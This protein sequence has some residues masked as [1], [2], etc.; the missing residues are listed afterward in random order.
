[1][2][3]MRKY[4][5]RPVLAGAA[6]V[7][8]GLLTGSLTA[9]AA[10]ARSLGLDAGFPTP[11]PID[12]ITAG[13]TGT[14]LTVSRGV[15]PEAFTVTILGVLPDGIGPGVDMIVF[16]GASPAL[17]LAGGIWAGM[18]GSPVYAGD[19]RLIGAVAYG[20]TL[21]PS[22]VGGI[23]PAASMMELLDS[24]VA[25]AR[26][27]AK[28]VPL[29][30]SLQR[31]VVAKG[32]A[33]AA[34]AAGG[35]APLPI[36]L[37][38]SGLT[39]TRIDR[40]NADFERSGSPLRAYA[41]AAAPGTPAD[42]GAIFAGSNFGAAIS[43]G[44]LTVAAIGTTT[45]VGNG[46]A[47]AF[48]HPMNFSGPSTMSAHQV[49]AIAVVKDETLGAFKMG[50]V[51]GVAGT[52]DQDRLVGL[53]ARLGA[54]PRGQVPVTSNV[55]SGTAERSAT[56]RVTVSNFL[57][58]VVGQQLLSNLDRIFDRIAAGRATVEW[59]IQGTRSNGSAWQ[60]ARS[61]RYASRFDV[62]FES[63]GE[64][65]SQ[66]ATLL[67]NDFTAVTISNVALSATVEPEFGQYTVD[68]LQVLRDGKWVNLSEG[69][70]VPVRPGQPLDL[71]VRLTAYRGSARVVNV[72]LAVPAGT[73][74]GGT[75]QI[76]G[77]AGALVELPQP[78]SFSELLKQMRTA[79]HNNE[80]GVTLTLNRDAAES[81]VRR[82]VTLDE[83]VTGELQ[84]PVQTS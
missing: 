26:V 42:G 82:V 5:R 49:N 51:G 11:V 65:A 69:Q 70:E 37:A 24:P 64:V 3:S 50:T 41:G 63:F 31:T 35:L 75:L 17:D 57:P 67:E 80:L 66:V 2:E 12:E 54:G 62:S 38:V 20:F 39:A 16:E 36:P 77:M 45:A 74:D 56:S 21:A 34:Q 79:P 76:T 22:K 72:R 48:G 29:P 47:L 6:L 71:R 53:R 25:V 15:T 60:L 84:F 46:T 4:G 18:S 44:D 81:V 8:G 19:G 68:K 1:M 43:Y 52:I 32:K 33:T 58:L 78:K 40:L 7:A 61:N 28:R 13:M 27:K 59:T 83:I 9:K 55:R 23:T 10:A 73:F 14:G 30:A